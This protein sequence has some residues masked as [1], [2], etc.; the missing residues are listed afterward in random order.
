M[1]VYLLCYCCSCRAGG[2]LR[3]CLL[4]RV[5]CTYVYARTRI[6][7]DEQRT[8]APVRNRLAEGA[9][10][11]ALGRIKVASFFSSSLFCSGAHLHRG[12]TLTKRFL[13]RNG[14]R[15][16]TRR[17]RRERRNRPPQHHHTLYNH[18]VIKPCR[19]LSIWKR[20]I[21]SLETVPFCLLLYD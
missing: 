7:A 11:E 10:T 20:S 6:C 8:K 18:S 16:T 4:L 21:H 9:A 12:A 19:L 3:E 14:R 1:C 15:D 13:T 17:E 5:R 2:V